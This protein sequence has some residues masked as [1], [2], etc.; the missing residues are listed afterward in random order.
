MGAG[1][2]GCLLVSGVHQF[3]LWVMEEQFN[4]VIVS[5]FFCHSPS[6]EGAPLFSHLGSESPTGSSLSQVGKAAGSLNCRSVHF[7]VQRASSLHSC[8]HSAWDLGLSSLSGLYSQRINLPSLGSSRVLGVPFYL[9]FFLQIQ[10]HLWFTTI[11]SLVDVWLP[12]PLPIF[13]SAPHP[14]SQPWYVVCLLPKLFCICG[15]LWLSFS[16]APLL[17]TLRLQ[18]SHCVLSV[19]P[20]LHRSLHTVGLVPVVFLCFTSDGIQVSL[21][22]FLVLGMSFKRRRRQK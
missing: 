7:H 17:E 13:S 20:L 14:T 18:L 4:F 3:T 2:D 9:P 1:F 5:L 15:A 19:T 12:P 8:S 11:S 6:P 21:S 10:R 22:C 16:C